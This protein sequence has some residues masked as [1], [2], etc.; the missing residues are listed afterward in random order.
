MVNEIKLKYKLRDTG[1]LRAMLKVP[2][3]KFVPKNYIDQAYSDASLPIGFGQTISQP[4]TVAFMARLLKLKGSEKV[5]EVGTGSG[6]Q[7]AVL[8]CLAKEVFSLEIIPEL[9]ERA[10]KILQELEYKNVKVRIGSGEWGWKESQPF[11]AVIITAGLKGKIPNPLFKQL[12][13]GGILI[14]PVGKGNDKIMYRFTKTPIGVRRREK[15]GIFH[16]V[17]FVEDKN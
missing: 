2:R 15:F 1:V 6:Y 16:F 14:A 9:A 5:L 8:S 11:D 12:K 7:A 4:Y 3:H 17:P 13:I 10:R